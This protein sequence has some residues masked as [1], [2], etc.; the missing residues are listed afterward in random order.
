VNRIRNCFAA[1]SIA[2]VE[3]GPLYVTRNDASYKMLFFKLNVGGPESRGWA[4]C[5]HNSG[6]CQVT[7]RV[8]GGVAVSLPPARTLLVTNKR[9]ANNAC[10]G[11]GLGI[12]Y[13]NDLCMFDYDCFYNV[14]GTPPLV[15]TW[16]VRDDGGRWRTLPV[17]PT[18]ENFSEATGHETHG[19]YADPMFVSTPDLGAVA[20]WRNFETT[21]IGAYPLAADMSVGDMNLKPGSPC[22]DA[23]VVIRGI[24]EDYEGNA[25]DMG[26]F[27]KE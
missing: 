26:A 19:I 4:Y 5:Y 2:P 13:G 8:Y 3:K 18:L 20:D 21:P 17:F 14:P 27:E 6:Y 16:Q 11:K 1:I 10:I 7:G 9:F 15:F 22:I 23:G 24:N 12:R 25:P